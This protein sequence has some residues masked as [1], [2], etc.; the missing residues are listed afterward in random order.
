MPR[1]VFVHCTR[2]ER[3][4]VIRNITYADYFMMDRLTHE[5]LVVP[6]KE[7]EIFQKMVSGAESEILWLSSSDFT[8]GDRVR[9]IKGPLKGLECEVKNLHNKNFLCVSLNILGVAITEIAP[10]YLEKVAES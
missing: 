6:D 3:L 4:E 5:P 1:V 7:M 8:P 2:T 9:V 10:S